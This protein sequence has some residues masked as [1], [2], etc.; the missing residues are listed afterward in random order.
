MLTPKCPP[1]DI[2]GRARA[3]STW[4]GL[5]R[6]RGTLRGRNLAGIPEEF[7]S[8]ARAQRCF[9]INDS[10]WLCWEAAANLS[11]QSISLITG[12]IQGNFPDLAAKARRRL[13]FPIISQL[14]TPKFPTHPNRE[15]C[16]ANRE[17][18]PAEQGKSLAQSPADGNFGKDRCRPDHA[19][20]PF[21]ATR[22]PQTGR[23]NSMYRRRP[24]HRPHAREPKLGPPSLLV[25]SL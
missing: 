5:C 6:F 16:R 20:A 11:R 15:F 2:R 3:N 7:G 17:L 22:R 14:L 12:K 9:Y 13:G 1:R 25:G 4:S 19:S 18:F 24:R 10:A 23:C 21:H 8:L